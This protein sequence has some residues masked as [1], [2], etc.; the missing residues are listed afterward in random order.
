MDNT[1][2]KSDAAGDNA[3]LALAI[4]RWAAG[5]ETADERLFA[6][7]SPMMVRLARQ[8]LS[9]HGRQLSLESRDLANDTVVKLISLTDRPETALHLTRLLARMMRNACIDLARQRKALKREGQRVSVSQ[10]DAGFDPQP[11]D[12]LELDRAIDRL[13]TRDKVAA[14]VTELRFFGGLNETEVAATLAVSRA[15]VTRKWQLARLFLSR[16]LSH[17]S[18][19]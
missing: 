6:Q 4:E 11:I 15:T 1:I 17:N 13:A 7:L 12:L 2:S 16:E 14:Q 10:I 9:R 8:Q 19:Q 18:E 5:D 3:G